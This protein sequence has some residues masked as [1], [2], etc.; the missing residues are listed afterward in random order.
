M[1][2]ALVPLYISLCLDST[3]G[4]DQRNGIPGLSILPFTNI[5][6]AFLLVWSS[7]A[8]LL[9]LSPGHTTCRKIK[10]SKVQVGM[11]PGSCRSPRTRHG[12]LS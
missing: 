1:S 5:C 10:Y 4:N 7:L 11:P 9:G 3:A 8:H 6:F 12:F 2:E